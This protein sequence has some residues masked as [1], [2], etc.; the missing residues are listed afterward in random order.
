MKCASAL[1]ASKK[2]IQIFFFNNKTGKTKA[3]SL[4]N[5]ILLLSKEMFF[6]PILNNPPNL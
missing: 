5:E 6:K 2:S 1:F 3:T 4:T